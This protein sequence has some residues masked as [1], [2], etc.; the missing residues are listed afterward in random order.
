MNQCHEGSIS[1]N[2]A[3]KYR[4]SAFI[5]VQANMTG[6]AR[7]ISM[8]VLFTNGKLPSKPYSEQA[9]FFKKE[10]RRGQHHFFQIVYRL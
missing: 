10:A 2:S 5:N 6:G 4:Y 1:G 9:D 7:R 8:D 3:G